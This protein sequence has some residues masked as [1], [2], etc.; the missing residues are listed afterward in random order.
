MRTVSRDVSQG[1]QCR[2]ITMKRIDRPR[3][4]SW[5][6]RLLPK[7]SLTGHRVIRLQSRIALMPRGPSLHVRGKAI[8]TAHLRQGD[9][10]G[11]CGPHCLITALLLLGV[12]DQRDLRQM[13]GE[14]SRGHLARFW[15]SV[16]EYYFAG[17][18]SAELLLM[19]KILPAK[20]TASACEF[21]GS[22]VRE[23]VLQHLASDHL[24]LVSVANGHI[25]LN[26]WVLAVGIEG[27]Q[28]QGN[29]F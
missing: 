3:S 6:D 21:R 27:R 15:R 16:R 24:V 9:L 19:V 23:F 26:H 2:E 5:T 12:I 4:A 13:T 10:D 18:S 7:K 14:I 8:S 11:A 22:T 1:F 20:V 29:L 17:V 28:R 25:G